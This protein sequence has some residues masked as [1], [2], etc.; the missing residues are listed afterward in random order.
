MTVF[1]ELWIDF[2]LMSMVVLWTI[3]QTVCMAMVATPPAVI[4]WL[5]AKH[6]GWQKAA[7]FLALFIFAVSRVHVLMH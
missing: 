7:L 1:D 6:A 5:I 4:T 2:L 3:A